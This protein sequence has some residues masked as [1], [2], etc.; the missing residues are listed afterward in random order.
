MFTW[1]SIIVVAIVGLIIFALVKTFKTLLSDM[2]AKR[3]K[4][5]P[6]PSEQLS[7]QQRG[8]FDSMTLIANYESSRD[9]Y[10]RI[11]PQNRAAALESTRKRFRESYGIDLDE[12]I[13][14]RDPQGW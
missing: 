7:P 12:M 4:P 10:R 14:K 11:P 6:S 8:T 13:R 5:N 2:E 9:V 3:R 1:S